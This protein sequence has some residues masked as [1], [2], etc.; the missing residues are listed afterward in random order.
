MLASREFAYEYR[1]RIEINGAEFALHHV[2]DR[3]GSPTLP[4]ALPLDVDTAPLEKTLP[5]S[6]PFARMGDFVAAERRL[7]P[8]LVA[9]GLPDAFNGMYGHV[10]RGAFYAVLKTY[11]K[12]GETFYSSDYPDL[13]L[14]LRQL[15][16]YPTFD[17]PEKVEKTAGIFGE[18]Y[19][20][21]LR[22][23]AEAIA[24]G[25]ISALRSVKPGWLRT[26]LHPVVH[27]ANMDGPQAIAGMT[28][29]VDDDLEE[30]LVFSGI[31]MGYKADFILTMR[32]IF[33]MTR[34]ELAPVLVPGPWPSQVKRLL[35]KPVLNYLSD[36]RQVAWDRSLVLA[37]ASVPR[38]GELLVA[39]Q[40]PAAYRRLMAEYG[41][42]SD[43]CIDVILS[44][45]AT[46]TRLA[47]IGDYQG[48]KEIDWRAHG[49]AS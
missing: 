21:P 48:V 18:L 7:G 4:I 37:E 20:S 25:D 12:R 33:E 22:A 9:A 44:L 38:P 42:E 5:S 39:G 1:G 10:S 15:R 47:S 40:R 26:M 13:Q 43:R 16:D 45:G 17:L 19:F 36:Q 2:T 3:D 29:H 41:A 11:A 30:A 23:I 34:M 32:K 27:E 35:A 24:T 6:E 46:V 49:L 31:V 14:M 28:V 8:A